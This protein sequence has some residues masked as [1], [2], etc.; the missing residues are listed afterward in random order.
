[1]GET[2]F[3]AGAVVASMTARLRMMGNGASSGSG[4]ASV[5]AAATAAAARFFLAL[6]AG[7]GSGFFQVGA[8]S[9]G[10]WKV[11]PMPTPETAA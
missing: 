10:F 6:G 11:A 8:T 3:W 1:M 4:G 7:A 5:S 9:S 2:T